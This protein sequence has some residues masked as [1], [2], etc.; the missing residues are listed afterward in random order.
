MA[1]GSRVNARHVDPTEM[2]CLTLKEICSLGEVIL[3]VA[4]MWETERSKHQYCINP[5]R[6][7]I[8]RFRGSSGNTCALCCRCSSWSRSLRLVLGS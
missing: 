1:D 3:G 2:G 8:G 7:T 6:D 4:A 5:I